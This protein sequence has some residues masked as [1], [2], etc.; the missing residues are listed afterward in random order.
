MVSGETAIQDKARGYLHQQWISSFWFSAILTVVV[1]HQNLAW[2]QQKPRLG[3][4]RQGGGLIQHLH[5]WKLDKKWEFI[6]FPAPSGQVEEPHHDQGGSLTL[7]SDFGVLIST[8][9]SHIWIR[10]DQVRE[11]PEILLLNGHQSLKKEKKIPHQPYYS[12]NAF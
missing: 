10:N 7:T 1:K 8:F 12:E 6:T 5:L 9:E 11:A 4:Y 3:Q 2:G